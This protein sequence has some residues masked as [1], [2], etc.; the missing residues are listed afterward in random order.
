MNVYRL[1]SESE[2]DW[3]KPSQFIR[4]SHSPKISKKFIFHMKCLNTKNKL[5]LIRN[6]SVTCTHCRVCPFKKVKTYSTVRLS[7][8]SIN[9]ALLTNT[10]KS[11]ILKSRNLALIAS[12]I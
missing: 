1:L 8:R 3:G 10:R 2:A 9:R 4:A 6:L 5:I 11:A 12:V 7:H